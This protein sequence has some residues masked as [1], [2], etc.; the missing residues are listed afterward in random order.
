MIQIVKNWFN[1]S[2]APGIL[3]II[4]FYLFCFSSLPRF[5][6]WFSVSKPRM[7]PCD[8][9]CYLLSVVQRPKTGT[10]KMYAIVYYYVQKYYKSETLDSKVDSIMKIESKYCLI[11][12]T[13]YMRFPGTKLLIQICLQ[14]SISWI[15]KPKLNQKRVELNQKWQKI[16]SWFNKLEGNFH[17]GNLYSL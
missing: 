7:L 1:Y 2:C 17:T 12:Y 11:R 6:L 16:R 8:Y 9:V 5:E 10:E 15:K 13:R 4:F 3:K 14:L